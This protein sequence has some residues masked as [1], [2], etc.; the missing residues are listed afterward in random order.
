[1]TYSNPIYYDYYLRA[2]TKEEIEARLVGAG[3]G[4]FIQI[5]GATAFVENKEIAVDHLGPYVTK[6]HPPE[7]EVLKN[8]GFIFIPNDVT[9]DS[10][11][12][13]NLRTT[14]E[15]YEAQKQYLPIIPPPSHPIK[16][17]A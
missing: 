14:T 10:R 2:D 7:S 6:E 16:R 13:T 4:Y 17:F 3:L 1:M 12:H 8:S 9:V 5:D 15:L 11:W